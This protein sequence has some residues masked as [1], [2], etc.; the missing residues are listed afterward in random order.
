MVIF[1]GSYARGEWV[2]DYQ[3][4]YEYVSDFDILVITKDRISAKRDKKWRELDRE[5]AVNKDLTRTSII[6]HSIGFVNDKIETNNY[7]FTDILKEGILLFDSENFKLSEP[8]SLNPE[9]RQKKANNAFKHWFESA[10]LFLE[11]A[12]IQIEKTWFKNA[13]FELHQATERYYAAILLVFTDYKPRTHDIE[14]LG[15]QVGKLH[16]DF[17]TVFPRSTPRKTGYL[18]F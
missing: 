5:L 8:K 16:P 4:K 3:E 15:N 11:T 2:E 1:F 14:E 13:A 10:N 17:V 18:N 7:F 12:F 9:E 6:Q